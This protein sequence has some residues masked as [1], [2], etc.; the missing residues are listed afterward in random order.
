MQYT[1]SDD[2]PLYKMKP[3]HYVY[4]F[5]NQLAHEIE[6]W[7]IEMMQETKQDVVVHG[8]PGIISNIKVFD[9]YIDDIATL[10]QEYP[11][12]QHLLINDAVRP[13]VDMNGSGIG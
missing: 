7:N 4:D 10:L 1:H 5:D 12:H 6:G 2:V 8:F 9:V 13:I 11:N 3:V